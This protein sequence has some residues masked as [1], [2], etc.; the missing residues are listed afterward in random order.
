MQPVE[1][2]QENQEE[3]WYNLYGDMAMTYKKPK[4][5]VGDPVRIS[6]FRTTFKKGYLPNWSEELFT[7]D[8][9]IRTTPVRYVIRDE[10]NVVLKGSFYEEEL[11][12]VTKV[13]QLYR[14][15]AILAERQHKNQAQI[16]VKWSGYPASFNS[17]IIAVISES[18]KAKTMSH[19]VSVELQD[20]SETHSNN[21][22]WH[23][24]GHGVPKSKIV[25]FCQVIILYSVIL[26]SIYNLTKENGD[27]NLWTALLS[28]SLGYLLPHPTIKRK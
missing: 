11:Q 18:I 2:H 21:H 15:E 19:P 23:F 27:S 9:V 14:I 3:V 1:V 5:N 8:K 16:L 4:F 6:K 22:Q 28:S 24:F 26:T 12:K 20:S 7:I 10:M 13:N 17:W 25:F